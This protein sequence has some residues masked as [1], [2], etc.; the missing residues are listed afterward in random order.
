[1]DF[2][3]YGLSPTLTKGLPVIGISNLLIKDLY[4]LVL[5]ALIIVGEFP[6]AR[7]MLLILSYHC[8]QSKTLLY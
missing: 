6:L 7:I 3:N 4:S 5:V 2:Y 1:M 8:L